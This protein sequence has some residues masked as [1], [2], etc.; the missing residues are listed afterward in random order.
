MGGRH[1]GL[2]FLPVLLAVVLAASLPAGCTSGKGTEAEGGEAAPAALALGQTVRF[3]EDGPP[4]IEVAVDGEW[5]VLSGTDAY[6]S[7]PAIAPGGQ[8]MA[9]IAPHEFEMAGEVHIYRAGER[10]ARVL[11]DRAAF[12]P[13]RSPRRL[14]W[15]DDERLAVLCGEQYGTIPTARW[16]FVA[17]IRTGRMETV[18]ELPERESIR[19]MAPENGGTGLRLTVDIYDENFMHADTEERR[20]ALGDI[21]R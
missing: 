12:P 2:R 17:D 11:L 6:P 21:G 20:V 8:T 5:T 16:L 14:L 7:K 4:F 18:L 3:P 15:L 10:Q 19:E 13:E 1:E 9:Y